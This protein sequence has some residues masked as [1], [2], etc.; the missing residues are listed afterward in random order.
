MKIKVKEDI[1]DK[2]LN[3]IYEKRKVFLYN[4]SIVLDKFIFGFTSIQKGNGATEHLCF[5]CEI[6]AD[7]RFI[8]YGSYDDIVKQLIG[9]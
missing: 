7:G 9:M 3:F 5:D 6:F 8:G 1:P 2:G 4:S